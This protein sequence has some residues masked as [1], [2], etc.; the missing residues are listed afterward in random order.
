[1]TEQDR[2]RA[3]L[4]A[5]ITARNNRVAVADRLNPDQLHEQVNTAMTHFNTDGAD[6][7]A[8]YSRAYEN[9]TKAIEDAPPGRAIPA[10]NYAQYWT[11]TEVNTADIS[12]ALDAPRA[13]L[14]T[15]ITA[16]I[17]ARNNGTP[18]ANLNTQVNTAM[19]NFNTIGADALATYT[20]ALEH[21]TTAIR[22]RPA[23][24]PI[25]P[26]DYSPNNN[27][28]VNTSKIATPADARSAPPAPPPRVDPVRPVA[29]VPTMNVFQ[30]ASK[31][32]DLNSKVMK[33]GVF[34]PAAFATVMAD[35]KERKEIIAA[36]ETLDKN[37]DNFLV[38]G[39]LEAKLGKEGSELF[40]RSLST[41]IPVLKTFDNAM[42][43]VDQSPVGNL[44]GVATTL[45][46]VP[47]ELQNALKNILNGPTLGALTEAA[48]GSASPASPPRV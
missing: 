8:N 42:Q 39:L 31:L 36:L 15:A 7:L 2:L 48:V 24:A 37:K 12:G 29:E 9:N 32:A 34:D 1:M 17:T 18:P 25:A 40:L 19:T 28:G 26:L 3:A 21:N 13:A 20:T 47:A 23:G 11:N 4:A 41:A 14:R 38:K 30:A 44:L 46:P 33:D 35:P 10:A 43:M 16:N 22:E 6:E 27:V 45:I 5:N